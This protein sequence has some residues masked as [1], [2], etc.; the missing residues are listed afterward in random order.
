ML[1][2]LQVNFLVR[3]R[4]VN[5]S[6]FTQAAVNIKTNWSTKINFVD[7][8]KIRTSFRVGIVNE[9][10]IF[11]DCLTFVEQRSVNEDHRLIFIEMGSQG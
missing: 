6:S 10:L 1:G 11:V 4:Y 8:T 3:G 7:P 2:N 5:V 9:D